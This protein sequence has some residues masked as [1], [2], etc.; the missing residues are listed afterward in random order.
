MKSDKR[1][2][3]DESFGEQDDGLVNSNQVRHELDAL[4]VALQSNSDILT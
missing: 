3:F 2:N 4:K 1:I